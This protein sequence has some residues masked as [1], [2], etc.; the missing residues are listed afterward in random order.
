MLHVYVIPLS[1]SV[2]TECVISSCAECN[3]KFRTYVPETVCVLPD[4]SSVFYR[5]AQML[6]PLCDPNG[7]REFI[8]QDLFPEIA[9]TSRSSSEAKQEEDLFNEP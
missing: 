9:G 4:G 8:N 5:D 1:V 3:R 2:H 7:F 6:C